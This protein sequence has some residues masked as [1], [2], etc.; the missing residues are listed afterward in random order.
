MSNSISYVANT[1]VTPKVELEQKVGDVEKALNR[2]F[3][4]IQNNQDYVNQISDKIFF[5]RPARPEGC[6]GADK[7]SESTPAQTIPGL[8]QT[9]HHFAD[10]I[11]ATNAR[12]Q[13]ILDCISKQL[14][15]IKL[16]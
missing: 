12:L 9:I 10:L 13:E 6:C 16:G 3:A 4:M 1:D 5:P 15:N 7:Q 8:T 11:E 14:G 2:L